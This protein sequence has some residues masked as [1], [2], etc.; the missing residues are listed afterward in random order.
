MVLKPEALNGVFV[1]PTVTSAEPRRYNA[2]PRATIHL[3]QVLV[4]CALR[5]RKVVREDACD[6]LTT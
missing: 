4:E 6:P 5:V 3:G 2:I 1:W